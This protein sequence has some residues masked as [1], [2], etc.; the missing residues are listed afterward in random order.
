[1]RYIGVNSLRFANKGSPWH[2]FPFLLIFC[3]NTLKINKPLKGFVE[4]QVQV[5]GFDNHSYTY[6]FNLRMKA[7]SK[8]LDVVDDTF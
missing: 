3:S 8:Y 7:S 2:P 1:M 6:V 4:Q 5:T